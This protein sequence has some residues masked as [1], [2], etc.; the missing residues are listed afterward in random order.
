M[1]DK[2]SLD[3]S[4]IISENVINNNKEEGMDVHIAEL[5]PSRGFPLTTA[6]EYNHQK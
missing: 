5:S 1:P 6:E 4:C 2:A 3:I